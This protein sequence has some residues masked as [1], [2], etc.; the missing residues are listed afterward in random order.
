MRERGR[1]MMRGLR[2]SLKVGAIVSLFRMIRI[3]RGSDP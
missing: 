1:R 3:F 2:T